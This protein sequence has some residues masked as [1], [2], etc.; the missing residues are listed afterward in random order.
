MSITPQ[1]GIQEIRQALLAKKVSIQE[2][3]SYYLKRIKKHNPELAAFLAFADE[4]KIHQQAQKLQEILLK[5]PQATGTLFGIPLAHKDIFCTQD[6]PTSCGSKIL[7]DFVPPYNATLVEKLE[8]Q[9]MLNLGK[10]NMDEFAMGGSNENSAF[11]P[12]KN[13]WD[14]SLVP[15][16]SSGGSAVAVAAGLV[17]AAS[18]TDTGGSVRQPAAFCGVTGIKPT[19]G[20][21]SRYGMVAFASSLD[22]AGFL[23]RN[24]EDLAYLL[25]AVAGRDE[26]DMTSST[27]PVEAYS[28][29]CNQSISGKTIAL[30]PQA[31]EKLP[32]Q[33]AQKVQEVITEFASQGVKFIDV[34]MEYLDK[35]LATYY[36]I[37]CA[38][39]S[40]NLSRYDGVHYGKRAEN[41][42]SLQQVYTH[43]RSQFLGDEVKRRIILG[44]FVLS[45]GYYDAYYLKALRVRRLILNEFQSIF[46]KAD[47][48]LMP[49]TYSTAFPL[50]Q[51]LDDPVA[52]YLQDIY[53][54]PVNLAGLP[55]LAL[56]ASQINDKPYGVQL[57]ANQFQENQLFALG[58]ALQRQTA[59]HLKSPSGYDD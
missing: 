34:D 12:A 42:H 5:D 33:E 44:T 58:S 52:L 1:S 29:A 53:T 51:K 4:Q 23:G 49:T 15:G 57:I 40:V 27:K 31:L 13:P 59:W 2:V 48:I 55:A 20:R 35:A 37:A 46:S 41:A 54:V 26:H 28:E 24:V 7:E 21:I 36:V 16:G 18:G 50:G 25:E 14:T 3:C 30:I 47:A 45:S 19:Y 39:A 38:E 6:M 8:N 9:G 10:L 11:A 17:P 22:Q 32:T 56:P 43:S